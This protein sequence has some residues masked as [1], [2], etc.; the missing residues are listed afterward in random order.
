[1]PACRP[2]G[3]SRGHRHLGR[4]GSGPNGCRQCTARLFQRRKVH[5]TV[6]SSIDSAGARANNGAAAAVRPPARATPAA[7]HV[8]VSRSSMSC[9]GYMTGAWIPTS[10]STRPGS[11][12]SR[13]RPSPAA[14]R[15]PARAERRRAAAAARYTRCQAP[16]QAASRVQVAPRFPSPL[17][18]TRR[19]RRPRTERPP[20]APTT[21]RRDPADQLGSFLFT[22]RGDVPLDA[23]VPEQSGAGAEGTSRAGGPMCV[24][25]AAR[26]ALRPARA[27]AGARSSVVWTG[28]PARRWSRLPTPGPSAAGCRNRSAPRPRNRTR[29]PA[30]GASA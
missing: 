20:R 14:E 4:Y 2:V 30:V 16:D 7:G 17:Q 8:A 3:R 23:E 5:E 15:S 24:T 19:Q 11:V 27:G 6:Q 10:A 22:R 21:P 12:T 26:R 9:S 29:S 13:R 25:V 18:Q 1:V 28:V